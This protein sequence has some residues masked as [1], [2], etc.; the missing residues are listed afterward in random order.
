MHRVDS[1]EPFRERRAG[2]WG[3]G[4]SPKAGDLVRLRAYVGP[5]DGAGDF[6]KE[7]AGPHSQAGAREGDF[8]EESTHGAVKAGDPSPHKALNAYPIS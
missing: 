5:G 7:A 6:G 1:K 2:T 3:S 8:P 4:V